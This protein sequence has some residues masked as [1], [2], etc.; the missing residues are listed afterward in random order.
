ML[1]ELW[2]QL[3]GDRIVRSVLPSENGNRFFHVHLFH[4]PSF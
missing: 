4:V 1:N 2:N 3:T